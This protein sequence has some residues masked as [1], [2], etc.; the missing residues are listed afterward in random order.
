[1]ASTVAVLLVVPLIYAW[2]QARAGRNKP[3]ILPMD[4]F[5]DYHDKYE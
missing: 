3:S 2:V 1:L 4:V 5:E